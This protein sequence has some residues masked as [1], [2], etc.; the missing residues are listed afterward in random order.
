MEAKLNNTDII[1]QMEQSK[2]DSKRVSKQRRVDAT[3]RAAAARQERDENRKE[4]LTSVEE[5]PYGRMVSFYESEKTTL[6]N[7]SNT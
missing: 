2:A 3:E 4:T 5:K 1:A 7:N 6:L